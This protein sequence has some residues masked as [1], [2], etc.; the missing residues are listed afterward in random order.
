MG[1]FDFFESIKAL[2][3]DKWFRSEINISKSFGNKN[4]DLIS[5]F[6]YPVAASSLP[7]LIN[8]R[9]DLLAFSSV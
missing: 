6:E 2:V 7:E 9:H 8:H 5:F 3:P 4:I 1:G